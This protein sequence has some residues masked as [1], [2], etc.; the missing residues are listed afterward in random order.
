MDSIWELVN[1]S[2]WNEIYKLV[3]MDMNILMKEYNQ[4]LLLHIICINNCTEII[5]H[6][7]NTTS[8]LLL[9]SNKEGENCLHILA[10]YGY[11]KNLNNILEKH[12][13]YGNYLNN[14]NESILF[15]CLINEKVFLTLVS[16]LDVNIISKRDQTCLTLSIT[17]GKHNYVSELLKHKADPNIPKSNLPLHLAILGNSYDITK[18]LINNKCDI[19]SYNS[20]YV[21]PLLLAIR[22]KRIEIVKLLIESNVDINKSGLDGTIYPIFVAIK[23]NQSDIIRLLLDN[24]VDLTI[25]DQSMNIPAHIIIEKNLPL[26]LKYEI[27]FLS[28]MNK[29]NI[30]GKTPGSLL[31]KTQDW[32]N[33]SELLK[34]QKL[35]IFNDDIV[36][37]LVSDDLSHIGLIEFN[38]SLESTYNSPYG[39]FNANLVHHCIYLAC[40]YR[41]YNNFDIPFQFYYLSK[42]KTDE[43]NYNNYEINS[44]KTIFDIIKSYMQIIYELVPHVIIWRNATNY[45]THTDLKFYVNRLIST[46]QKRFIYIKLTL[47]N[48]VTMH[49]NLL[50]YDKR[51]NILE[52]FEPYGNI[53]NDMN[54]LD[55]YLMGL[56]PKFIYKR[57][58][59]IAHQTISNESNITYKKLG[60]PTGYCLAWTFWFLEKKLK[61]PDKTSEDIISENMEKLTLKKSGSSFLDY[62]RTYASKLDNMKNEF[63]REINVTD[64]YNLVFESKLTD[65]LIHINK[66]FEIY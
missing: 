28:D 29:K 30:I 17:L 43:D 37:H 48:D 13:D 50:L 3:K 27:L 45:F 18:T 44:D 33:Y 6:I 32:K 51:T 7:L 8:I 24:K 25:I 49:A 39:L 64:T 21:T 53:P 46:S 52:R 26:S 54:G 58:N 22:L 63:L 47:I 2:K 19:N 35:E 4:N 38:A 16:K 14:M 62:I 59:G 36:T 15:Y 65:I 1:E 5:E 60:D 9:K 56:F 57:F 55:N 66:T 34:S 23:T 41:K 11:T 20:Q 61:Y 31:L 10:K 12:A 40:F 42:A